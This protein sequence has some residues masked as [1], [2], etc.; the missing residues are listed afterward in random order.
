MIIHRPINPAAKFFPDFLACIFLLGPW[1]ASNKLLLRFSNNDDSNTIMQLTPTV[2]NL[3]H[4]KNLPQNKTYLK[5]EGIELSTTACNAHRIS[6]N[7]GMY[8]AVI[9]SC[10]SNIAV[11]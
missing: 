5:L 4:V 1:F 8:T 3:T 10:D 11:K 7:M 6:K 2:S 9:Y